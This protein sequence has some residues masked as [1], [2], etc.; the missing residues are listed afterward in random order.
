[1][2]LAGRGSPPALGAAIWAEPRWARFALKPSVTGVKM[3]ARRPPL[4]L[5]GLR[6][7]SEIRLT[8]EGA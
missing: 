7:R 5:I 8:A 2:A 1:M 6:A 4:R 3:V